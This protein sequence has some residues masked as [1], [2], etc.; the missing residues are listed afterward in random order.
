MKRHKN[1]Y[2]ISRSKSML[3]NIVRNILSFN[4]VIRGAAPAE[5]PAPQHNK[6]TRNPDGICLD[7]LIFQKKKVFISSNFLHDFQHLVEQT[8][9]INQFSSSLFWLKK[10]LKGLSSEMERGIKLVSINNSPFNHGGCSIKG[11][12]TILHLMIPVL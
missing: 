6:K 2:L 12:C 4:R 1:N 5:I 7:R 3:M 8:F 11:Q 9:F 10:N